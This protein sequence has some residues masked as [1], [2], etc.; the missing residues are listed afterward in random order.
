M[1]PKIGGSSSFSSIHLTS[2]KFRHFHKKIH[3]WIKR[4]CCC[5]RTVNISNVNF[6]IKIS[7]PHSQYSNTWGS[8]CPALISKVVRA[9]GMNPKVGV[10]NPP[11]LEIFSVPDIS[12]I[13]SWVYKYIFCC[14]RTVNSSNVNFIIKI[15][16]PPEPV[17]KYMGQQTSG[18]DSSK[19]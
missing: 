14:P 16:I 2:L 11:H 15:S 10:L 13:R 19:G 8:K 6:T 7:I 12:N 17:F 18:P 5:L 4:E 1:N 9:F 3:S